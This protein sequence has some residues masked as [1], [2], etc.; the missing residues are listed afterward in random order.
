MIS[1]TAWVR[2]GVAAEQP[3]TYAMDDAEFSRIQELA[4]RELAEARGDLADARALGCQDEDYDSAME[5]SDVDQDADEVSEAGSRSSD[6]DHEN[7][8]EIGSD[9]VTPIAE[10]E[11]PEAAFIREYGLDDYDEGEGEADEDSA[12]KGMY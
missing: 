8:N 5:G 12:E 3:Q 9:Q 4:Q 6:A 7:E 10:D 11:D 2:R 1:C